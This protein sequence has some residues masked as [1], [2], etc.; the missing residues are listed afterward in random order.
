MVNDCFQLRAVLLTAIGW[1]SREQQRTIEYLIE[2]NRVLIR[3]DGAARGS[4]A[5]AD[6]RSAPS[7]GRE[8]QAARA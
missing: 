5:P 4:T 6:E 2:E 8:G 1:V 7:P 3:A